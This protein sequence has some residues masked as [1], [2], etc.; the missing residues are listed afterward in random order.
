MPEQFDPVQESRR[1]VA[2]LQEKK[3]PLAAQRDALY[4]QAKELKANFEAERV[5]L[6]DALAAINEQIVPI[7]QALRN[8]DGLKNLRGTMAEVAAKGLAHQL[9]E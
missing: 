1:L 8:A 2:A 3:Q 7:D 5:K 4:S 9:G 6:R